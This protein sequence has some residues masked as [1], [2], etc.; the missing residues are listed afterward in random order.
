VLRTLDAE[1][2]AGARR[3]ND[4]E[5]PLSDVWRRADAAV[6]TVLDR[7]TFAELVR[8]WNEKQSRIE[9]NWDI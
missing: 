5:N 7:A 1:K 4:E 2:R 9:P 6:S 8:A 3:S